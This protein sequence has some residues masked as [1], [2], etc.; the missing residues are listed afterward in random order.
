M[1]T[2][3]TT[4]HTDYRYYCSA[5]GRNHLVGVFFQADV[6]TRT[7]PRRFY[8]RYNALGGVVRVVDIFHRK[9]YHF[10]EQFVEYK[11]RNEPSIESLI[12][13]CV[14]LMCRTI[15]HETPI[16]IEELA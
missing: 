6:M 12:R 3:I 2:R 9:Q 5:V 13:Q 14:D 4:I 1:Q 15:D 16:N 8:G 7:G 10:T 11:K